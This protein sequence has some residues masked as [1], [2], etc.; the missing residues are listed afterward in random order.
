MS[1]IIYDTS[2]LRKDSVMDR[3]YKLLS[4]KIPKTKFTH[5]LN[6]FSKR[7]N[8][9]ILT[10]C[11]VKDIL[12]IFLT[13]PRILIF[14]QHGMQTRETLL[15]KIAF[16]LS[17]LFSLFIKKR[18]GLV[19]NLNVLFPF[20]I[21]KESVLKMRFDDPLSSLI[22][23]DKN[24]NFVL[25]IDQPI[26]K[27][28]RLIYDINII[29][30]RLKKIHKTLLIKPHPR[31]NLYIKDFKKWNNEKVSMVIGYSSS[32]LLSLNYPHVYSLC[33]YEDIPISLRSYFRISYNK[34]LKKN[35]FKIN[36]QNS[37]KLNLEKALKYLF[38]EII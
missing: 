5:K 1:L 14:I 25:F 21:K 12:A 13:R 18:Y 37:S 29:S 23:F 7:V 30:K 35:M 4:K 24:S 16:R 32:I 36:Y 27:K 26:L 33:N 34:L 6:F 38:D 31:T 8:I 20:N 11:R 2:P 28:K 15:K 9:L 10:S 17:S 19:F 3:V 22:K